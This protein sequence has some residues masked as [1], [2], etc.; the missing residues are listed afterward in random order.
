MSGIGLNWATKGRLNMLVYIMDLRPTLVQITSRICGIKCGVE[1]LRGS[2]IIRVTEPAK[3]TSIN[4]FTVAS[5]SCG[6]DILPSQDC[7]SLAPFEQHGC[8]GMCCMTV[9]GWMG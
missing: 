2:G 3:L 9:D 5:T 1:V 7:L 8:G 4:F 6:A